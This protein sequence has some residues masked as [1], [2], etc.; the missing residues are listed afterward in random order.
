MRTTLTIDDDVVERLFEAQKRLGLS[1]KEVVN[2]TL[3]LGLER[4]Y[5]SLRKVPRFK[6]KARQMGL[7]PG[8]N[9][10]NVGEML[11]QLEGANH[12]LQR[13]PLNTEL[14][15]TRMTATSAV[16]PHS[17]PPIH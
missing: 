1:F 2:Q 14:R 4:Q 15:F 8:V 5:A 3:R 6:V 10:T 11:E 16:F 12:R 17:P 13:W 9:Y 7:L